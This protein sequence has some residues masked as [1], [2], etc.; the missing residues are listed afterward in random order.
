MCEDPQ[1]DRGKTEEQNTGFLYRGQK[2]NSLTFHTFELSLSLIES[3]ELFSFCVGIDQI[4]KV[5]K[6]RTFKLKGLIL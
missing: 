4:S 2:I 3:I 5:F 1:I 6:S